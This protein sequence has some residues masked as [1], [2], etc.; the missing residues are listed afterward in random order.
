ML[1]FL[2]VILLSFAP[3]SALSQSSNEQGTYLN[4]IVVSGDRST[5]KVKEMQ[6]V[7]TELGYS[8]GPVDGIYGN[9]TRRAV[10]T[11]QVDTGGQVTERR[12]KKR[13]NSRSK[14]SKHYGK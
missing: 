1:R 2:L 11:W 7:L 12:S 13:R 3:L 10:R 5:Q 6:R 4:K 14:K 9:Q 8:P